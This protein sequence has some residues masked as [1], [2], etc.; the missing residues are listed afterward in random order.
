[1]IFSIRD[2]GVVAAEAGL[3]L[4]GEVV[5]RFDA[6]NKPAATPAPTKK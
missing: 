3:D 4:S 1:M 5:K 2:S 6:A